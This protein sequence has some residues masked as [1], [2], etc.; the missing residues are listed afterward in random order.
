M[1][2]EIPKLYLLKATTPFCLV[3]SCRAAKMEEWE[4]E[5][6]EAPAAP[7]D[8]PRD[9]T[10]LERVARERDQPSG[11]PP[12]MVVKTTLF[13][14]QPLPKLPWDKPRKHAAVD[15]DAFVDQV[16][17]SSAGSSKRLRLEDLPVDLQE[18]VKVQVR[19]P[20]LANPEN[21]PKEDEVTE[22]TWQLISAS[23]E[24][25]RA[26]VDALTRADAMVQLCKPDCLRDWPLQATALQLV[27][28]ATQLHIADVKSLPASQLQARINEALQGNDPWVYMSRKNKILTVLAILETATQLSDQLGVPLGT[29]AAGPIS[30]R[31]GLSA[32]EPQ[33]A[34]VALTVSSA[35]SVLPSDDSSAATSQP[36]RRGGR[37]GGRHGNSGRKRILQ[38][39][40]HAHVPQE[41]LPV[42]GVPRAWDPSYVPEVIAAD[43]PQDT[44]RQFVPLPPQRCHF[45]H[46]TASVEQN[47]ETFRVA[48]QQAMLEVVGDPDRNESEAVLAERL[49]QPHLSLYTPVSRAALMARLVV[50]EGLVD[51]LRMVYILNTLEFKRHTVYLRSELTKR[52]VKKEQ[53]T[54]ASLMPL[55]D[56]AAD[57][58]QWCPTHVLLEI[59]SGMKDLGR[60][61]RTWQPPN[62]PKPAPTHHAAFASHFELL[63]RVIARLGNGETAWS[64]LIERD[65]SANGRLQHRFLLRL[66]TRLRD[67]HYHELRVKLEEHGKYGFVLKEQ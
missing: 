43:P 26:V 7:L 53:V 35:A 25:W 18:E 48:V 1:S 8:V 57:W 45:D 12:T 21:W 23:I 32:E 31:I 61:I 49:R 14:G 60:S 66:M 54:W 11:R 19:P 64:T 17:G 50:L 67:W 55:R 9:L 24:R 39:L 4:E 6:K 33:A 27:P 13:S 28:L 37:R 3:H 58:L 16:L 59:L 46:P 42:V 20:F 41:L 47:N 40:R 62:A 36:G 65:N 22:D 56:T 38:P 44:P 51:D 63:H 2:I 15:D 52:G 30:E 10:E 5:F 29:W 34:S